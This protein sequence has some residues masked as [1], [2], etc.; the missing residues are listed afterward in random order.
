MQDI[1]KGVA[2]DE[3]LKVGQLRCLEL[4]EVK[5]MSQHDYW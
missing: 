2:S 4:S 3:I 5:R 1:Q